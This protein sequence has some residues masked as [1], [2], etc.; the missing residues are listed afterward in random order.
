MVST[1]VFV[2]LT[3]KWIRDGPLSTS[4]PEAKDS[5]V[6]KE[7]LTNQS[8][9][10]GTIEVGGSNIYHDSITLL[11]LTAIIQGLP[12][13]GR[14][15]E[16]QAIGRATVEEPF[17]CY[18]SEEPFQARGVYL[19]G[20]L[21]PW[22]KHYPTTFASCWLFNTRGPPFSFQF[23]SLSQIAWNS[24]KES[25]FLHVEKERK[26]Y[27]VYCN[28]TIISGGLLGQL[29]QAR[30]MTWLAYQAW[31]TVFSAFWTIWTPIV[32]PLA[33]EGHGNKNYPFEGQLR[34]ISLSPFKILLTAHLSSLIILSFFVKPQA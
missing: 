34:K 25:M 1:F 16:H 20:L 18:W 19:D 26:M 14:M 12:R 11:P 27:L 21:S 2:C 4:G 6:Q 17:F 30:S 33:H 32:N 5:P 22:Y 3:T 13:T 15:W 8:G 31:F 23:P 9:C 24:T 28:T 10:F 29:G 7:H